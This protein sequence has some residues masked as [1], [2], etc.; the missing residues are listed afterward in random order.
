MIKPTSDPSQ[1]GSQ[2]SS[3]RC[4]FPYWDGLGVGH[5]LNARQNNQSKRRV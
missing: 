4:Q 3:A 1:Q 5:G 2:R